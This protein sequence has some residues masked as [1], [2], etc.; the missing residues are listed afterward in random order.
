MRSFWKFGSR[1]PETRPRSH[2]ARPAV[3]SI[4][5]RLL[6]HAGVHGHLAAAAHPA[7]AVL[8]ATPRNP[9]ANYRVFSG[10]ITRGP[11]AGLTLNGPLVL[12]IDGRIQVIGYLF[13]QG[14]PRV[15]VVGTVYGGGVSLRF[16]IPTQ[17]SSIA[18]EA[19][20]SG[21]LKLVP[22][23]LLDGLTLAGSGNLSGP[24]FKRD[25]GHWSTVA[26]GKVAP[27]A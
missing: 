11:A 20:G 12:G 21:Q 6:L 5:D 1:R 8:P 27:G 4:E 2:S 22:N 17:K 14:G 13:Q 18:V 25:F 15:T 19:V 26:P 9:L 23:G 10:T 7:A 24:D 16:V 3:E